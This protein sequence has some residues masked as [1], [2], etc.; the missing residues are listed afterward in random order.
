[1]SVLLTQEC[2]SDILRQIQGEEGSKE[3]QELT[4]EVQNYADNRVEVLLGRVVPFSG[5]DP[6]HSTSSLMP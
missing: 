3:R 4:A 1:M 6:A 5:A 2:Q